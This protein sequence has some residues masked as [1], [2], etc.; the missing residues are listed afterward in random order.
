MTEMVKGQVHV[1]AE[2]ESSELGPGNSDQKRRPRGVP[3]L[4]CTRHNDSLYNVIT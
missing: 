4:L 3:H 2:W 1:S